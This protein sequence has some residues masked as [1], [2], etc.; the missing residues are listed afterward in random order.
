MRG[1]GPRA[2]PHEAGQGHGPGSDAPTSREPA[3]VSRLAFGATLT[4]AMAVGGSTQFTLGALG[5]FLHDDLGLSRFRLGLLTTAF[6]VAA[7]V[8]SPVAGR[9]VDVIGGR[10]ALL[11]L[12][13]VDIVA[14]AGMA[15]TGSYVL[16][17]AAAA[18]SG[19]A[20]AASNPAT[21]HLVAT[22]VPGPRRGA[23]IGVKQSGVQ[24]AA[25]VTGSAMPAAAHALG[26]QGALGLCAAAAAGGLLMAALAVPRGSGAP[27]P[28]ARGSEARRTEGRERTRPGPGLPW[29]VGYGFLMGAGFAAITAYLPLYAVEEAHVPPLWAGQ[30]LALLGAVGVVSRL[31]W[32]RSI[33]RKGSPGIATPLA[34]IAASAVVA[35]VLVLLAASYGA[36]LLWLAMVVFGVGTAA[37]LALAMLVLVRHPQGGS[38]GQASGFVT[39]GYYGGLVV[40]PALFSL[41]VR[42][43]TSY[44]PGW[45]ATAAMFACASVLALAWRR[46]QRPR[47]FDHP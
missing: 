8:L 4:T 34:L 32:T 18:L 21:N 14:F 3:A 11:T 6:F 30:L 39:A 43:G 7:A 33:G 38:T 20:M 42:D 35:D 47:P 26:W 29:L 46:A 16:V 15:V 10:T 5:P 27:G 12:F 28:E 37:W 2:A 22:R 24:L 1:E 23:L 17:L 13:A 45:A 36:W 44:A 19:A 40:S 9:L 31:V 25:F 41:A